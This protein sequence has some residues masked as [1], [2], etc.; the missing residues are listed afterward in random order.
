VKALCISLT[1]NRESDSWLTLN[2]EYLVLSIL[3]VPNGTAKLRII[4]DDNRTPILV[5]Y[6]MFAANSQPLPRTWVAMIGEGGVLELGPRR[7]LELGFWERYF[8]GDSDAVAAFQDEV[9]A[10]SDA[11][12]CLA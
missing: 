7:W 12:S 6:V 10:M 1:D 11:R 5:D 2:H 9:R 8:D 3:F 4:A